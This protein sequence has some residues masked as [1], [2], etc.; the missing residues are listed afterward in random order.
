[1]A[2][3]LRKPFKLTA[4]LTTISKSAFKPAV[5]ARA[6]HNTRST[7]TFFTSKPVAPL[8]KSVGTYQNAFK[9][10]YNNQTINATNSPLWQ[11]VAVGGA[12][13]GGT[14]LAINLGE[15][16]SFSAKRRNR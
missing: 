2:F 16:E 4:T 10:A 5:P 15:L 11:R 3:T 12:M 1:M 13:F 7:T 8:S 14:L 6:F 9:R